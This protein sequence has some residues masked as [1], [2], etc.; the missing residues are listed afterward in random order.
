MNKIFSGFDVYRGIMPLR[1][2]S[3]PKHHLD[4]F[5]QVILPNFLFYLIFKKDWGT[6]FDTFKSN[7]VLH[8]QKST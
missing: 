5:L 6:E 2:L 8:K 3:L 4:Y 7:S 1:V